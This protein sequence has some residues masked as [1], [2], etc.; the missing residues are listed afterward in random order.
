MTK[1]PARPSRQDVMR[2]DSG[3]R[4]VARH[5]RLSGVHWKTPAATS[6]APA[7]TGLVATIAGESS[8][9]VGRPAWA[10]AATILK[11]V[12]T[13]R[14]PTTKIAAETPGRRVA[15]GGRGTGGRL[16]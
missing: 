10:S 12:H 5:A 2:K 7:S 9:A 1:A 3:E 11:A 6:S 14:E 16:R 4:Q 15:L 8:A 13:T